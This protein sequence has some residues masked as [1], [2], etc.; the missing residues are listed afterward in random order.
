MTIGH[1]VWNTMKSKDIRDVIAIGKLATS[2]D[3][4]LYIVQTME[5]VR[6]IGY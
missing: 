4:V 6:S 3:D 2:L 1:S 5:E